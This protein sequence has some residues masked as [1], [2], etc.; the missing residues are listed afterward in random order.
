MRLAPIRFILLFLIAFSLLLSPALAVFCPD[1]GQD[2][3]GEFKF[4]PR[5]GVS[6]V[7]ARQVLKPGDGDT[8]GATGAHTRQESPVAA[9][10][11]FQPP[12]AAEIDEFLRQPCRFLL[13]FEN[14]ELIS[15]K[16]TYY[17]FQVDLLEDMYG[18]PL[19]R[20]VDHVNS[21]GKK[22]WIYSVANIVVE[23]YQHRDIGKWQI[24]LR[25]EGEKEE[26]DFEVLTREGV[27]LGMDINE[28]R[29]RMSGSAYK[30]DREK[31]RKKVRILK[32]K[33]SRS[34]ATD[35]YAEFYFSA[36]DNKLQ[37]IRFGTLSLK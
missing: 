19:Q 30:F 26:G 11:R 13:D 25:G 29:D 27:K 14:M 17:L 10:R 2:C 28:V 1:C 18:R 12:G 9:W 5:C 33:K 6:L 8:G 20:E 31:G 24:A 16:S 35:F 7:K 3:P 36:G 23:K 4:C 32:Y 22:Y 15:A 34:W 37:K 21:H